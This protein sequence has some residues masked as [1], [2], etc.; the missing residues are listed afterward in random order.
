MVE[1]VISVELGDLTS[2]AVDRDGVW[3]GGT[4]GIAHYDIA[5]RAFVFFNAPG[6]VPGPVLDL[7]SDERYVWVAT[8]LGLVRFEKSVLK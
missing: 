4:R 5:T 3:V 8:D 7:T 6:D 2:V 1:R